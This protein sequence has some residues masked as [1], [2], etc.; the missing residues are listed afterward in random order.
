MSDDKDDDKDATERV[1][2][3]SVAPQEIT[4]RYRLTLEFDVCVSTDI[5]Q[6]YSDE[7]EL[8]RA[9]QGKLQAQRNLLRALLRPQ[10]RYLL[11][12]LIR[13]RVLE[14]AAFE[15]GYEDV[16]HAASVRDISE[17]VLLEPAIDS[18]SVADQRYYQD[19]SEQQ[20]FGEDAE[21]VVNSIGV[22]LTSAL[23]QKVEAKEDEDD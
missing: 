19:A 9:E 12:E 6:P 15:V 1:E 20:R 18:L 17:D 7:H 8:T 16:K 4:E 5:L 3:M 10:Y 13:K 21:D 11:D 23:L 14:E 22:D 2:H